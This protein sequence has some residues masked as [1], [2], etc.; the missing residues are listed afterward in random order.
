MAPGKPIVGNSRNTAAK[1]PIA[2][3]MLL[4]KYKPPSNRPS[5]P[6]KRLRKPPLIK[7]KVIP[8]S[9]VCGRIKIAAKTQRAISTANGFPSWG[10]NQS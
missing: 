1:A 3:P 10:I 4:E 2:A 9:I 5:L 6:G 7:G 8:K